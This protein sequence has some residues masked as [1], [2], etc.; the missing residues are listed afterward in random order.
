VHREALAADR[1]GPGE[2][3]RLAGPAL[4]GEQLEHGLVVEQAVEVVHPLGVGTVEVDDVGRDPL[5]EVRLEARHA[6]VEEAARHRNCG[7][8]SIFHDAN[9]NQ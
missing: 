8:Q 1:G 9:S 2:H 4:L 7:C 5:A 6:H 3:H